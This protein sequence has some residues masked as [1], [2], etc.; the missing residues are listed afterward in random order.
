MTG[1]SGGLAVGRSRPSEMG[2]SDPGVAL[3]DRDQLERGFSRLSPEQRAL[4]VLHYYL[5]L[6]MHETAREL[7]C[8]SA[9]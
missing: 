3:A 5:E 4:V 6:P 8:P 9:R 1:I 7:A 2:M